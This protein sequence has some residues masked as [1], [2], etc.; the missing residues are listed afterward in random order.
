MSKKHV[1]TRIEDDLHAE[2]KRRDDLNT[3]GAIRGFLQ[4]L[5]AGGHTNEAALAVRRERLEDQLSDAKQDVERIERKLEEVNER[6]DDHKS[7]RIE[8]FEE[9]KDKDLAKPKKETGFVKERAYGL[10]KS[11][12]Q[13]WKEY[14]QWR[15]E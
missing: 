3:A 2:L 1:G 14:Q 4:E 9:I 6:L 5:V 11:P 13:F 12:E 7:E 8:K 10:G 15:Q